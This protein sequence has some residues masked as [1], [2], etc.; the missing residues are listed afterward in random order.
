MLVNILGVAIFVGVGVLF[1]RNRKAIDF[2]GVVVSLCL[3]F[4]L[5]AFLPLSPVGRWIVEGVADA[6]AWIVAQSYSGIG[7]VLR[8]SRA[9]ENMGAQTPATVTQ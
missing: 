8:D 2:K 5:A 7:F 9:I 1:S 3:N 6:F 4:A